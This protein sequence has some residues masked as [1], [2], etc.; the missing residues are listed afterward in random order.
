M[1]TQKIIWAK[2]DAW[3]VRNGRQRYS[4]SERWISQAESKGREF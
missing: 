1:N 4:E 2:P 3:N